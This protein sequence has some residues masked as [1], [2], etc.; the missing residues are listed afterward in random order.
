MAIASCDGDDTHHLHARGES[1]STCQGPRHQHLGRGTRRVEAAVLEALS[2]LD[3][4]AYE[5]Q[6]ETVDPFWERAEHWA[7]T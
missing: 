3:R 1:C 7:D 4:A 2:R 5:A 6:P